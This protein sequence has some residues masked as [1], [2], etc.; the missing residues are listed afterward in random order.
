MWEGLACLHVLFLK[1]LYIAVKFGIVW[2][3]H[4]MLWKNLILVCISH[5]KTQIYVDLK[6]NFINFWRTAYM[7]VPTWLKIY[8]VIKICV[9]LLSE[10]FFLF[11][12]YVMQ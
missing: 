9:C 7:K 5:S 11:D 6:S 10:T 12:E 2:G 8:D 1:P 3:V 4:R